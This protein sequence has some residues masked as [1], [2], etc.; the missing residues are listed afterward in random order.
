M[1]SERVAPAG[2]VAAELVEREVAPD[3]KKKGLRRLQL[4]RLP[5]AKHAQK[6]LLHDVVDRQ[7]RAEALHQPRAQHGGVRWD[8]RGGPAGGIWVCSRHG[9]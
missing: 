8:V 9:A 1:E 7:S 4:A 2:R 6:R 3:G 5:G